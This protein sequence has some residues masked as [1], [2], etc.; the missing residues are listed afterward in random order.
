MPLFCD[1]VP[2]SFQGAV[3]FSLPFYDDV[4]AAVLA[5]KAIEDV[6]GL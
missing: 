3:V 4:H 6:A 5:A 2:F 1:D